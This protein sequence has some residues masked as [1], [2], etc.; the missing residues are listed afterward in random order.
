MKTKEFFIKLKD[1]ILEEI[2]P[3][4]VSCYN[5]NDE[6]VENNKYHLC[7]NCLN[8]IEKIKNPCI[9]C[10]EELNSFTK[11]C[12]NCKE[13]KRYFNKV[14][15]V[16]KYNGVAKDLVYKFKYGKEEYVADTI[17]PF[18][19]DLFN[20]TK[21]KDIDLIICVPLSE[22]R[23]KFRGF[24]QAQ[25]LAQLLAKETGILYSNE[26][27]I[28]AVNT[29]TQTNLNKIERRKNLN[30][31]FEIVSGVDITNKNILIVDDVIT[32]GSTMNEIAKLL[33]K[34]KAK[35]VYGITFCHS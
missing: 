22:E 16:S 5:C 6:I 24:N 7:A 10:G 17:F 18:M 8:K 14:V 29:S 12:N 32:T 1:N 27:I 2:F 9:K 28:R 11:Y 26:I 13:T 35:K 4:D 19:L 31:V 34:N 21:F 25:I 23:L 33:K 15:S 3:S 30:N 20:E